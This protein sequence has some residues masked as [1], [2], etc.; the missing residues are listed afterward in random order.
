M[1]KDVSAAFER[2]GMAGSVLAAHTTA[3]VSHQLCV[4]EPGTVPATGIGLVKGQKWQS[5]P[6]DWNAG[7]AASPPSG[8]SCMKFEM[9]APQY[10]MYS[11]TT[12]GGSGASTV[13][14]SMFTATANGDLNGDGATFSTFTMSGR[15]QGG[16]LALAPNLVETNPEE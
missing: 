5:A 13:D 4:D 16:S 14:Q 2:E 8:F 10:Y 3:G 9:D 15:V 11:Y 6:G 1:A 7:Q 12:T